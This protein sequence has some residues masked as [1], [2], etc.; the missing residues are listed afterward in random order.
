MPRLIPFALKINGKELHTLDELKNNFEIEKVVGYFHDGRLLKWLKSHKFYEVAEKVAAIENV[1]KQNVPALLYNIF[2][3][4]PPDDLNIDVEETVKRHNH[5]TLVKQ[6][7]D[8][9]EILAR[10][11]VVALN[12]NELDDL[13]QKGVSVIYLCNGNYTIPIEARDKTYIGI[14]KVVAVIPSTEL[15]DFEEFNIK[16]QNISFDDNYEKISKSPEAM[17]S[18]GNSYY[19]KND[20]KKAFEWYEKAAAKGDADAMNNLGLCYEY[21]RG[22]DKDEKK[23]VEW[24]KKAADKGHS[25]AKKKLKELGITY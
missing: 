12:Q 25:D 4:T 10:E 24:F 3:M 9:Q 23:A 8:N 16:F 18:L 7:T 2:G 13:I 22:V 19:S 1:D 14:E 17:Y 20:Y 21:G 6:F 5:Y 11:D 15:V